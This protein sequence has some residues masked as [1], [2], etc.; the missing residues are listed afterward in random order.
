MKTKIFIILLAAGL[1]IGLPLA[2]FT[3]ED[4]KGGHVHKHPS[5]D[6]T[7]KMD[8]GIVEH[9]GQ[10]V[11]LDAVFT[12]ENGKKLTIKE[13]LDKPVIFAP[14]YY[15][16]PNVC[17][18]LQSRLARILPEIKLKHGVEYKVVSVSFDEFD[19]PEIA[20]KKKKNYFKAMDNKYPENGWRFLTGDK[21]NIKKFMDSIG[22]KFARKGKDFVHAVTVVAVSPSGKI[23]RYLYGTDVLPF[24]FTL[25]VTE[26]SQEKTGLS[27]KKLVKFCFS[28]DPQGKKYV[29]NILRVTAVAVI[30]FIIIFSLFLAFGGKKKQRKRDGKDD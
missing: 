4:I 19:T 12:D 9:L 28:Y 20:A 23:A 30:G 3:A 27:V 13:I 7:K 10:Q 18:F 15:S 26:A 5:A 16:C 29:F 2:G 11:A 1:I 6:E 24:E 22:F 14:V 25:A 8:I 21:E 17:N